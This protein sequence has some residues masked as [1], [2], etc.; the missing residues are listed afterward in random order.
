MPDEQSRAAVSAGSELAV[1][2]WGWAIPETIAATLRTEFGTPFV[3]REQGELDHKVPVDRTRQQRAITCHGS[4]LTDNP[5]PHRRI[6]LSGDTEVF[7]LLHDP[8][9][10]TA[11]T[12][13]EIVT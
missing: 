8:T 4:Q 7:R 2:V 5:V 11:P 10:S 3:G 9:P 12:Q 1:P 6:E 13:Q